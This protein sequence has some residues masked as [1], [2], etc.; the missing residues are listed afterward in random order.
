MLHRAARNAYSWWWASHIRT[1]QSKWLDQNLQD[2]EEKVE[3]VLKIIDEDGESFA[4]RAEMYY[5]RRPELLNF[6]EDF[7]RSYR[8][9]AERFDH[10]SKDLQTANRTIA[11]VYPERVQLSMEDEDGEHFLA[12]IE[13][14]NESN[15]PPKSLPAAPK[16]S[17]PKVP[18]FAKRNAKPSRLMSKKGLIKF[19]VDNATTAAPPTSGLKKSEALQEI[20]RLQKE[21][22]GLQTEKEFI[23][24]SYENGLARYWEIEEHV[25]EMQTKV[26]SLQD[27]FGIGTMIEDDEARTLMTATALNSCQET[28]ARLQEKQKQSVEDVIAEHQ[29]IL[30]VLGKFETLKGKFVSHLPHPQV[31]SEVNKSSNPDSELKKLNRQVETSETKKYN[32]EKVHSKVKELQANSAT[33]SMSDLAEKV[34]ELV[35]KVIYLESALSSQN[36]YV[37]RLRAETNELHSHLTKAEEE[38]GSLVEDSESMSKRIR[39]LE[40]ELLNVQNLKD[41][42]RQPHLTE[43]SCSFDDLSDKLLNKKQD[44]D[45]KDTLLSNKVIGVSAVDKAK[46]FQAHKATIPGANVLGSSIGIS[47]KDCLKKEGLQA[48]E[49]CLK[50]DQQNLVESHLSNDTQDGQTGVALEANQGVSG[51]DK[52]KQFQVHETIIAERNVLGIS[53]GVSTNDGLKKEGL[54][55]PEG[56]L[57]DDR[58]N[59]AE[60]H[61]SNDNQDGKRVGTLEANYGVSG[62]DKAKQIQVHEAV[63][64]GANV[65][66]I[67]KGVSTNDGLKKEGLQQPEGC[68]EDDQQNYAESHSSND[69]QDGKRVGTLEA[70]HGVS[71][72]D[73]AKQFQ[74]HEEVIPGENVQGISKR[75]SS[76]EGLKKEVL[77]EHERCLEIDWQNFVEGHSINNTQ[78]G[79]M[80]GTSEANQGISGVDKEKQFQVHEA[81]TPGANVPGIT[82]GVNSEDGLKKEVLH[83]QEV[84]LDVDQKKLVESHLS[85][86]PRDGQM[87]GTLEANQGSGL[88]D[89]EMMTTTTHLV[90]SQGVCVREKLKT[91]ICADQDHSGKAEYTMYVDSNFGN[92][93]NSFQSEDAAANQQNY[94]K[95]TE[96]NVKSPGYDSMISKQIRIGEEAKKQDNLIPFEGKEEKFPKADHH[97]Q[98]NFTKNG[99]LEEAA[100]VGIEKGFDRSQHGH[101][102]QRWTN[103]IAN[104]SDDFP[105]SAPV[106]QKKDSKESECI[107]SPGCDAMI[108]KQVRMGEEAKK[109]DIWDNLIKGKAEKLSI[110]DLQYD[111]DDL[112]KTGPAK[113]AEEVEIEK[114]F[115]KSQ[116]VHVTD[117]GSATRKNVGKVEQTG[118]ND[119]ADRRDDFPSSIKDKA[120]KLYKTNHQNL[121]ND[122]FQDA[123]STDSPDVNME[124]GFVGSGSFHISNDDLAAKRHVKKEKQARTL[125]AADTHD[126]LNMSLEGKE[127]KL[128]KSYHQ[129]YTMDCSQNSPLRDSPEV[130]MEM[131][132]GESDLHVSDNESAIRRDMRMEEQAGTTAITEKSDCLHLPREGKDENS[133]KSDHLNYQYDLRIRNA[134]DIKM[135]KA[136][137]ERE[138]INI[139]DDFSAIREERTEELAVRDDPHAEMEESNK[140]LSLSSSNDSAISKDVRMEQQASR[141]NIADKCAS[142]TSEEGKISSDQRSYFNDLLQ[143]S[144][145]GAT[146]DDTSGRGSKEDVHTM[147]PPR[148]D[149]IFFK[150]TE[151]QIQKLEYDP[152]NSENYL[153]NIHVKGQ[154]STLQKSTPEKPDQDEGTRASISGSGISIAMNNK[155]REKVGDDHDVKV[156]VGSATESFSKLNESKQSDNSLRNMDFRNNIKS[157]EQNNDFIQVKTDGDFPLSNWHNQLEEH[158][159]KVQVRDIPSTGPDNEL[160]EWESILDNL[161]S[162]LRDSKREDLHKDEFPDQGNQEFRTVH[163]GLYM[164]QEESRLEDDQPNWRELFLNSLDDREKILLEEYTSVLRNFKGVKKKLND[165]EKKRRASHFQY[166]VQMKVL[167]NANALKDAQI[168]SLQHRLNLLQSKDVETEFL[169][170][171]LAHSTD[172]RQE[173]TIPEETRILRIG[174]DDGDIKVTDVDETHSFTTVEE[175][176]RMDIDDLLEENI[177]LWLRFSTSFHQIHKFQTSVQDLQ[178]EIKKVKEECNQGTGQ[179]QSLLSGIRPIYRHLREIQTELTLWL[180]HNAMLKDDLQHRLSSLSNILD[181]ITRLS[182]SGSKEN[183]PVLNAYQA[184]KFQG[185]IL[186][187]K[188]ENN[189]LAGELEVG[190]ECIRKLQDEIRSTLSNLDEELGLKNQQARPRSRIPLRSFLFGVKLKNKRPSI[191]S[192]VNPALQKQYSDLTAVPK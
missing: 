70:N 144:P 101:V 117:H 34:D 76:K 141:I 59:Y 42:H 93:H 180:D 127:E 129:N 82:K 143:V 53:K 24:S 8:A 134:A 172:I 170:K 113:D 145:S 32:P 192:C 69:T 23:K 184:A 151:I 187:M 12:A 3:Y 62:V 131:R 29:K 7:F 135:E 168:L 186:N 78:E 18:S 30:E 88:T 118:T 133:Q 111:H 72:V 156:A 109:Q 90:A 107:T 63:I 104:R 77:Q 79:Q 188:Q 99:P 84:C 65:L 123:P 165:A 13:P 5:R 105:G 160:E 2:M 25:T 10:L 121:L 86:D 140:S 147:N 1:K 85:N 167:K 47:S 166:V 55:Q 89:K 162:V 153:D 126:H 159:A 71:G 54:Q 96:Y 19:N 43:A 51:V 149:S 87:G 191:F 48:E 44:E 155:G 154:G 68:L 40:E 49:G 124:R 161:P 163:N 74:V 41:Y 125:D 28:L 22:L 148:H 114:G 181:V 73:K 136:Y 112:T 137:R 100:D 56:C 150:D 26:S 21:I 190:F 64:P 132:F 122:F 20:D 164:E 98:D 175:K 106:D 83:E 108:S 50:V 182:K 171:A 94:Y 158:S 75:V 14:H 97:D 81:I 61:S 35:D 67:S 37:T 27:E 173:E 57:E 189:K 16:L 15:E 102:E 4:S 80:G 128:Y 36:A 6:I 33:S 39:Q 66:G 174:G 110:S 138:H 103:D 92:T 183:D 179:P 177:E 116:D 31:L 38:K 115:D 119:L 11:T 169:D 17:V 139:S 120:E 157:E 45:V 176:V 146:R 185:E 91:D 152:L 95:G 46:Q 178:A 52:A 130:E 60:S 142:S 58:Q 9:L